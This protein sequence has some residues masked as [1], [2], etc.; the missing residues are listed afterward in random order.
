MVSELGDEAHESQGDKMLGGDREG[1]VPLKVLRPMRPRRSV[2]EIPSRSPTS[3]P[4]S[5]TSAPGSPTSA[6]GSPTSAPG[7]P[8][9]APGSPTSAPGSPTSAPGSPTSA[10]GSP[11]SA[12]GSPTSA[13]GS[14][15]SAPSQLGRRSEPS[16]QTSATFYPWRGVRPPPTKKKRTRKRRKRL[17]AL[18][19]TF[20]QFPQWLVNVMFNIEEAKSHELLIE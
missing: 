17:S 6:P 19:K 1:D 4:G 14:P 9:S 18:Q 16:G 8:T 7:S 13:P 12:P 5:P 15:T 11:T 3:A 20:R 10:P 2:G